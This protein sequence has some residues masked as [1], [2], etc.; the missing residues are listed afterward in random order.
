M[1]IKHSKIIVW[2]SLIGR[3]IV[4]ETMSCGSSP[5]PKANLGSSSG[6]TS[7]FEPEKHSSNL[8]PRTNKRRCR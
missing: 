7:G 2:G 8:C 3:T 4:S 1:E 5:H 6:R